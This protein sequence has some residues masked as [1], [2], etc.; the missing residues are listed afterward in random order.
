MGFGDNRITASYAT[1]AV[2]GPGGSVGGFV[3]HAMPHDRVT[4]SYWDTEASGVTRGGGGVG[5]TTAALQEPTG[6]SGPYAAWDV[7]VDGDGVSDA[8]WDFGTS[9]AYPALS[10]DADGDGMATWRE[11]G[12]QGRAVAPSAE[13]E[14]GA[15]GAG[16]EGRCGGGPP[17]GAGAAGRR[18][19]AAADVA[20][21]H[22]R[23]AGAGS[24][25][26]TGGAPGWSCGRASTRCGCAR[27]CR[28]SGGR[29]RGSCRG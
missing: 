26:G 9:S 11:L 16:V 18:G 21:L 5:R 3:G 28:R 6:Y 8:P 25:A 14:G 2:S 22:R 10:V 7:D 27:G 12:L 4:A 29:T 17:D 13:S 19:G 1:G 20:A 23:S 24:D 15:P